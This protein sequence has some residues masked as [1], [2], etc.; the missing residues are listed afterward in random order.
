MDLK[1]FVG[2]RKGRVM[3][4]ILEV[5]E[6]DVQ[7]HLDQDVADGFKAQVRRKL[8]ELASDFELVLDLDESGEALNGLAV[9]QRDR[10][11]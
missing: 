10:L 1:G 5:F 7:P 6:E 8:N 11:T 4:Q 3:A 2:Q 9:H